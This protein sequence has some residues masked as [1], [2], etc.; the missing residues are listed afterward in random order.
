MWLRLG[1][2]E[3]LNMDMV[4]SIKRT[5]DFTIEIR[6]LDPQASRSIQFDNK[7]H[8]QAAFEKMIENLVKMG[9]AMQ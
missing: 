3:I 7:D 2:D 6:Y 1:T 4:T 5:G 9:A 8:C